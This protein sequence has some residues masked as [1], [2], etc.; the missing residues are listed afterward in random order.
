MELDSGYL[1]L[2]LK[3]WFLYLQVYQLYIWAE[4][5]M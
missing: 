1:Q 2:Q 4:V 5:E 3:N